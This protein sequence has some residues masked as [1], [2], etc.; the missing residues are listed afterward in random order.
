MG[1]TPVYGFPYPSGTDSPNGPVQIQQLAEAV[2]ADLA[3]SDANI[4][5]LAL[6][7]SRRTNADA[8]YIA[9]GTPQNVPSNSVT[10]LEFATAGAATSPLVVPSGTNNTTFT[11]GRAGLWWGGASTRLGGGSGNERSLEL[12]NTTD[13]KLIGATNSTGQG[14]ANLSV[15]RFFRIAASGKAIQAIAYQS[16]GVGQAVV[17]GNTRIE[18]VWIRD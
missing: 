6:A 15:G 18:L 4:A 13:A 3:A 7:E 12:T 8:E 5:A 16:T 11:L 17:L 9:S 10:P 1:L 14:V 2:E